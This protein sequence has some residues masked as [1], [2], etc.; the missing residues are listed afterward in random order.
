MCPAGTVFPEGPALAS[1]WNM[2][3]LGRVYAAAA[4]EARAIGVHQIFT[5][6]VEPI[7]D[8]R[9]GRNE[10]AF[11]EDSF[12]CVQIAG[13]IVT[14]VQGSDLSANDK[15]VAGLC[16]FPGQS[17]PVSGLERGAME[18]PERTLREV[19]LPP[20]QTGIKH[21]GALG[22]MATYPA[23]DGVPAHASE[24]LLTSILRQELGFDGLVLSEG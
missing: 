3:L 18:I 16:H 17:Q 21:H 2:E 12:L 4:R 14:S 8:P 19:F 22:V 23:I 24:K 13:T 7:R 15:V 10:E 6:V 9:L 1:T 5:L 11:S 20:W